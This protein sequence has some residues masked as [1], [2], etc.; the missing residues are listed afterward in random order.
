MPDAGT[1]RPELYSTLH[2]GDPPMC[3]SCAGGTFLSLYFKLLQYFPYH[4]TLA[5]LKI[6]FQTPERKY[7]SHR[8]L[9]FRWCVLN[10]INDFIQQ[11][12]C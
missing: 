10:V 5:H 1:S 12:S 7:Q 8:A 9:I 2:C 3:P 4:R 6:T 11:T